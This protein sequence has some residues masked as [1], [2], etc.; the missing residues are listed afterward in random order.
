MLNG[1]QLRVPELGQL[2]RAAAQHLEQLLPLLLRHLFQLGRLLVEE[3][4]AD[5][6]QTTCK[7]AIKKKDEST[8]NTRLLMITLAKTEILA[9]RMPLTLPGKKD[10]KTQTDRIQKLA[11]LW[12]L[13]D[14]KREEMAWIKQL[15]ERCTVHRGK[16]IQQTRHKW[17]MPTHAVCF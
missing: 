11:E 8:H 14:K 3:I 15:Y 7:I 2:L 1:Q 9:Y 13:E 4:H 16:S 17:H 6:L 10:K 5:F 12:L